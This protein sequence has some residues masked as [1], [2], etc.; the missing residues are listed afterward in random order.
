MTDLK[1]T[2]PD[3]LL[4]PLIAS[5]DSQAVRALMNRH[6]SG[7]W[8]LARRMLNDAAMADDITQEVFLRVWKQA[9]KWETGRAKFSTWIR[10]VTINLCYDRLRK[11]TERLPGEVPDI[12]DERSSVQ[13]ELERSELSQQVAAAIDDL[14]DRQR[15]AI[16]LSHYD[17]LSQKDAAETL[18]LS[19]RAYESL[20]ARARRSLKAALMDSKDD[21]MAGYG[22]RHDG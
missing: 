15:A 9:P 3:A 2:D 17:D 10:R 12:R 16:L 8:A 13:A 4:L 6:S 18:S 14:P 11:H 20:L 22:D 21:L 5:G 1:E 19:V 7:I